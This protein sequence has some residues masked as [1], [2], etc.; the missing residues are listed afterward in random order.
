MPRRTLRTAREYCGCPALS[1]RTELSK[2]KS[3]E[4][5]VR[6]RTRKPVGSLV[7]LSEQPRTDRITN[8]FICDRR[9]GAQTI[10]FGEI[11]RC[12]TYLIRISPG[13]GCVKNFPKNTRAIAI[14]SRA[15]GQ[16]FE[17]KRAAQQ[18][19]FMSMERVNRHWL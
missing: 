6:M 2:S 8:V 3:L 19:C 5:P 12:N 17:S 10:K 11:I 1:L 16:M 15:N 14:W 18:V 13:S 7:W 4:S 9:T